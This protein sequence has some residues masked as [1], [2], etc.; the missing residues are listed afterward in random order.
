VLL[1][2]PF[3]IWGAEMGANEHGVVI[4]NEGLQARSP[5]PE[6]AALIGMDLLRLTLERAHTAAE[7]VEILTALLEEHGQGGNCGHLTAAYYHNG[8]MIADARDAFVLETVGRE[9]LLE[10]V[11]GVRTISNRYSIDGEP[12]RASA[13]LQAL[14]SE[15][16]DAAGS[17]GYADRLADPLHEHI[18]TAVAR[19]ACSTSLL[20]S[21]SG[22]VGVTDTINVLRNHGLGEH[23]ELEWQAECVVDPRL[24]LHA[25]ADVRRAQT[26]GSMVS[27]LSDRYAVH[28]V[29]ATAA[30]CI[31][32]FKPVVVGVPLPAQGPALGDRFDPQTLWWRHER[33]HRAALVSDFGKFLHNIRPERD[34]LETQFQRRI[35]EVL[36]GGDTVEVAR[37]VSEC[38]RAALDMEER[39]DAQI[40][41][42][43]SGQA[44]PYLSAWAQMNEL[45]GL[46]I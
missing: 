34:Q 19:H 36:K 18:K 20:R 23:F 39:W 13:G 27:Q 25:G 2:R 6:K 17:S 33:L 22:K 21:V 30:P 12:H 37:A 11:S 10:R 38:W 9:W 8:F 24:C 29:T 45:A 28:W 3:W 44:A 35:A 14:V 32:I 41:T 42:G 40:P 5:A 26:V 1:C 31:S 15:W 4:G 46:N 43:E 7:A 16:S